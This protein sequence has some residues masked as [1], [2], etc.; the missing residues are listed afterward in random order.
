MSLLTRMLINLTFIMIVF[1]NNSSYTLQVRLV[2]VES[3]NLDGDLSCP[4]YPKMDVL[5]EW[6][7]NG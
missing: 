5:T 3:V 7:I 1:W 4:K 2:T 6:D